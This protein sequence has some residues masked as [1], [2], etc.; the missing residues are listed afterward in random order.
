[1]QI[2]LPECEEMSAIVFMRSNMQML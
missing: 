2:I 1:M